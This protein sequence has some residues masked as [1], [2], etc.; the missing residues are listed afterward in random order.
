MNLP[1]VNYLHATVLLKQL[2]S[3]GVH[4]VVI[5]PGSRSTPLALTAENLPELQTYV[6]IDERSAAFFALGLSKADGVPA[7][8]IC[9]SGTAAANYFPALIETA[10]SAVPL[11]VLTADRPI[12][13]RHGGAPQ[14]ID[15]V[16]L[17]GKYPRF[18]AD[19]PEARLDIERCR[20]VRTLAAQTYSHAV[21]C[22]CGPAHLNIPLDEPLSP[23][24][25]DEKACSALWNALRVEG[26]IRLS[27]P[28]S[29]ISDDATLKR[30][31]LLLSDSLCGLIVAG[32]RAAR[33]PQDAEAIH[34]LSRQLGWP[35][36]ADITSGMHGFGNPVFPHYDIF[37]RGEELAGLAPDVVLVI[38]GVPTSK[39]L[40]AYLDHH[41]AAHTIHICG[42]GLPSDPA[43]RANDSI[44]ADIGPLCESLAHSVMASRDSLLYEP[45]H[46]ASTHVSTA[47]E[48]GLDETA[49]EA[50]Y[51]LEAVRV[52]PDDSNLVLANSLPIRYA[53]ALLGGGKPLQ[54]FAMRGANGIDGTISHAAGVAAASQ[55]PTLLVTGDLAFFHDM[56]GLMTAL[57]FAP[58]LSLLLL[59]NNGGGIF[60]FLPVHDHEQSA[61]F[62][63]LHGTP[64]DL[65]LSAA[66]DLFGLDWYSVANPL[67]IENLLK[68]RAG[69]PFVIEVQTT[70]ESN[71]HAYMELISRLAKEA[72]QS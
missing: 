24:L 49:C 61:Q 11:I 39:T 47:L 42:T 14:T 12:A 40:N 66:R 22:P 53:D 9:T 48:R 64:H 3:C 69:R 52:M 20:A 33:K 1:N 68:K 51:V 71:H 59:N 44:E 10:Q 41:R 32:T 63:T 50:R 67:E 2:I 34:L 7:I 57:R 4:R 70:R 21:N 45:F 35:V 65:N 25:R 18:F 5:S 46:Q 30:L 23:M 16:N 55:K 60:H 37:L 26:E 17:Y 15:Q 13:S 8:L 72:V 6:L 27:A 56:N 38:G 31:S 19:L 54:I 29:R 36:F 62:E 43:F 58:N 28:A